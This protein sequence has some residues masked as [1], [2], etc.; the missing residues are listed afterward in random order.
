[1][2][3]AD[4]MLLPVPFV[5]YVS[6]PRPEQPEARAWEPDW[7]VWRPALVAI[8]ALIAAGAV[9]GYAGLALVLLAFWL[10]YRAIDAALPYRQGLREHHQ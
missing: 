3:V 7:S 6:E 4:P 10:G 5:A 2:P 8:A 1:M 9:H